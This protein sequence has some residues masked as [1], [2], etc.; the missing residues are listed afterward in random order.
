MCSGRG[1]DIGGSTNGSKA[2]PPPSFVLTGHVASLVPVL[3]GRGGVDDNGS[4]G[5]SR[6]G[7]TDGGGVGGSAC[8]NGSRGGDGS[9][10]A[11]LGAIG[12]DGCQVFRRST[13]T[14]GAPTECY[15]IYF[16]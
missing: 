11:V 9:R 14:C 15:Y 12:D 13:L 8:R 10:L 6:N 5:G 2:H 16:R 3:S 4:D 1:D 7:S